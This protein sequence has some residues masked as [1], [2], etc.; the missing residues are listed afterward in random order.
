MTN[1][2]LYIN[3]LPNPS[4]LLKS[5]AL[6]PLVLPDLP[7]HYFEVRICITMT[8]LTITLEVFTKCFYLLGFDLTPNREADEE[9]ISSPYQENVRIEA[10]FKKPFPHL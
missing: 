9:H 10:H 2:V 1:L 8:A 6:H 7:K 5:I 4:E 3:G